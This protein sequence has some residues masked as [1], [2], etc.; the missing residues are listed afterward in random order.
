MANAAFPFHFLI[1]LRRFLH[2]WPRKGLSRR[3]DT[4]EPIQELS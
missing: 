2:Q 4:I 1:A 3:C